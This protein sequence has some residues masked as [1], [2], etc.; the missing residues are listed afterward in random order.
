MS[1]F[2]S[3]V[4]IGNRACQHCGVPL[5][6]VSQ[7]FTEN[8]Q[9]AVQ[10]SSCYD[11][12][13]QAE[14]RRNV[15]RFATRKAVLRPMDTNT[16]LLAPALW[17]SMVTYY[18]GSIVVDQSGTLWESLVPSN[19]GNTPGAYGQAGLWGPYFGPLSV[20]LYD[21]SQAYYSGEVVYTAAGNGTFNVYRSMVSSNY[22]DPGLPNLWAPNTTYFQNQ[23]VMVYPAWVGGTSYG[24]GATVSYTDGNT[25]AS[26]ISANLGNT[27]NVNSTKWARVPTVTIATLQVPTMTPPAPV[28]SSPIMEWVY[29]TNYS[30]GQFILWNA[31]QYVSLASNNTMN[32]PS[33][34]S[35][36]APLTGG[37]AY[38]SLIDLNINQPP[39]STPTA[40]TTSFV[41][42]SGNQYWLQIGGA[43]FPMGVG[44]SEG[45][46]MYP[47]GSGP[48]SQAQT[49]NVYRLPAAF[50]R[51]APQDPKAGSVSFLGAPTGLMYNDWEFEANYLVTREIDP[52]T[53][54]F[55]ADFTSVPDMDPMFCEGLGARI[56][57]EVCETLTQSTAKLINIE[58]AYEKFMTEA[59]LVNG[60]ETGAE[61]PPEDDYIT[62]RI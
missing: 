42:G 22:L 23:V 13:R 27:P 58:K 5:I 32:L 31:V 12:L 16:M 14:L 30:L 59:R 29:S 57:F 43:A 48:S 7:G 17:S 62:C 54:R 11:K 1:A 10:I 51:E 20:M 33:N 25:Y 47:V 4:D 41:G 45:T 55:V 26:L 49:R 18:V 6:N 56:A 21:G 36:W 15:W 34:T 37:I 3:S 19:L 61:E 9:R 46:L 44:L 60:I 50:L 40:W 8:S 24:K 38:L 53:F 35:F 2:T 52:I 28:T 39:V